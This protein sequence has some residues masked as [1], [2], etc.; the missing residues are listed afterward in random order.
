M[1]KLPLF[2]IIFI[3]LL[4]STCAFDN[5]SGEVKDI[6]PET[7]KVRYLQIPQNGEK[8]LNTSLFADTVVYLPL[9]TK[10]ESLIGS[11]NQLWINDSLIVINSYQSGLLLFQK[12]GRFIKKIG[13]NGNG[14]GEYLEIF[15]FEVLHDTIYISSINR[16][17]F[18]RYKLDGTFCGEI[19]L[20]YQPVYFSSTLDQKIACYLREEGKVVVY[21]ND[22]STSDTIIVEY[23]VTIGRYRYTQMDKP[24]LQKTNFG[25]LFNSYLNDTIWNINNSKKEPAFILDLKDK[26]PYDK[27]IEFS[28]GDFQKWDELVNNF[29]FV[30][31]LPFSDCTFIFQSRWTIK[32]QDYDAIYFADNRAGKV[33]KFDSSSIYDDMVGGQELK[34][35]YPGYSENCLLSS[36]KPEVITEHLSRS[37]KESSDAWSN[38]MKTIKEED[39]P[40][41]VLIN[42]KKSLP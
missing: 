22:F 24:Y 29:R 35:F 11:I 13:K 40:I 17:G 4:N 1:K 21:N 38:Q 34:V 10:S 32:R 9:E 16:K 18:L 36:I 37:K 26:L 30:H 8:K 15:H 19:K 12:N 20:N 28:Q 41:L 7:D 5:R 33:R 2:T 27:Q 14:P 3:E 23:G 39:N 6:N 31:L 25:L 42:I